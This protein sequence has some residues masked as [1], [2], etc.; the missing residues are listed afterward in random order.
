M[1]GKNGIEF[2]QTLREEDP[3]LPFILYTGKWSE[4]VASE[5]ISAGATDCLQK[6]SGTEQ[7]GLLANRV[8]NAAEQARTRQRAAELER[9]RTLVN[10]I[11]QALIRA[12]SRK[13]METRVCEIISGSDPYLFAW[14]GEVDP[15]TDRV[16]PC[17]W[18]GDEE[19]Y[20]EKIT[21]TTDETGTGR[22]P[23]GTAIREGRFSVSQRV[24]A[25]PDFPWQAAALKRG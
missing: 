19:G 25:D 2:L 17:T 16:V 6:R 14:I 9:I 12:D 21:L 22:G 11:N 23:T 15:E 5:A 1:P 13:A 8:L 7:Y 24:A 3:D 10:D 4:E 20:L 18:A